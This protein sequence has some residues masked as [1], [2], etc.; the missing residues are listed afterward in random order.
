MSE[1]TI[2]PPA[3]PS[4]ELA[5]LVERLSARLEAGEAV[6]LEAVAREHPEHAAELRDLLPAVALMVNLSRSGE[7]NAEN[8]VEVQDAELAGRLASFIDEVRER[9]EPMPA[10]ADE[11]PTSGAR[12]PQP[13]RR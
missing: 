6:D 13:G 7:M 10:P 4:A 8:V 12:A 11:R 5:L 3:D 9:Y 1:R 2:T